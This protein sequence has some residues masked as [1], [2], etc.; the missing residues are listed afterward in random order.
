MI[1]FVG[2][3][4]SEW[5]FFFLVYFIS[6]S[7]GQVFVDLS[8]SGFRAG[9]YGYFWSGFRAGLCAPP[10]L[11]ETSILL[12]LASGLVF[13]HHLLLGTSSFLVWL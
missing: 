9:P 11:Q 7:L 13:V 1:L 5:C 12:V 8:G 4:L 10:L 6:W 3:A 2:F